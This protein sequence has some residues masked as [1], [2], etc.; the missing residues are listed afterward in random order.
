MKKILVTLALLVGVLHT[1]SAV[2]AYPGRIRVIQPDGSAIFIRIHGDEWYHYIT[3]DNGRVIAQG[4]DGFYLPAEKPSREEWEEARQ[5]RISAQQMRAKAAAQAPSLSLGEHRIPV[6]LVNFSDKA[7]VIQDPVTAF[8]EMLNK[9]GYSRGGATGSVRDYYVDNSHG[10]YV[11]SFDVYGP[12]T[13]SN[14]SEYYAYNKTGRA[15]Q[16]VQEA[17]KLLD[18]EIDFSQYDSN[19]D[20]NVDMVLM[21]FA[22]Y[23]QA[24]GGGETT[25]WPH[26]HFTSGTFDGVS[27][28]RYFCTSEL[29]GA[30]GSAMGGIGTTAHEFAHSL[31]LPDFY[32]TDYE[33]NGQAGGLYSFS[34]MCNGS[35]NN[36]GRTPPYF[37]S[38]E[39]RILG[40]M[41][42]QTEIDAQGELTIGPIQDY[43]A[44]RT[45]TTMEGEYFV[46][47]CRTKTGWDRYLPGSGMLVYHV[48]KSDR[49]SLN[50]GTWW[51][52]YYVPSALWESWGST[53][54]IN[55]FGSHPCFYLVPAAAQSDLAY[56][57][58][59]NKIPFPGAQRVTTYNP[60]DWQ[61]S[62]TDFRFTDIAFDGTRVTMNVLYSA[63]PGVMGFVRNMSAKPVR[64]AT[65]SLYRSSAVNAAPAKGL[66]LRVQGQPLMSVQTE[67]DGSYCFEDPSLADDTFTLTVSCDGYLEATATVQ[68]TRKIEDVDFYIRKVD[69]PEE[70]TFIKYDPE[71]NPFG[72]LGYGD[73]GINHAAAFRLSAEETVPYDG[74]Q[75]KLI[76]FQSAGSDTTRFDAAYVFIESGGRRAFTQK[77]ENLR[78]DGMNTVNV[79]GQ[80]FYITGGK[81]IYIGY[82]LVGCNEDRPILVQE[83]DE[84]N[85]GFIASFRQNGANSWQLIQTS[86]GTY[87]TPVISAAVGEPV[88]P[89]LG[90]NHI[91]NPGEGTY[92]AGD[93][94]QLALVRY[95]DDA[96]SSVSWFFDGKAVQADS[97]SLTAG[98]HAVEAHLTYPDGSKEVIRLV[99]NVE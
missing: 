18:G 12:V 71:G 60:V 23:N 81:E 42:E 34:L 53:N 16:A 47:E 73:A 55:A 49:E 86:D 33:E 63:T 8:S 84:E 67:A 95:E 93:R 25:I 52:S 56:Y 68:I 24:E 41:G 57:G 65:V 54:A 91:A 27:L 30:S 38:E 72:A 13:L 40:W 98:S 17:C 88:A 59:E 50:P 85:A 78:F 31:G 46:Y 1:L 15:P 79:T 3:D 96:P 48:D 99:I 75:I 39:L 58:G 45:P 14:T 6:V 43:V 51:S 7:F 62:H 97:V 66:R 80:E 19:S 64:G 10:Q 69:E 61:E 89:E 76:S 77:V 82:A 36:N 35:Y 74:K 87:Y 28:D 29:K 37:N 83:C 4:K 21:Y 9:E 92:K 11:P 90:F 5:M 2:P 20:G 44:Y 26:S 70:S 94:F 32:D 22:G